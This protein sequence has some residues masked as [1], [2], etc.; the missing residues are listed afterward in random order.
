MSA[1]AVL[2]LIDQHIGSDTVL[3]IR[4]RREGDW[5]VACY[6]VKYL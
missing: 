6:R 1:Q 3:V 4:W 2:E 5:E